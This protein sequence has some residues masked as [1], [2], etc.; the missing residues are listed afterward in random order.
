[1][2]RSIGRVDPRQ[3]SAGAAAPP[4]TSS[5]GRQAGSP[6]SPERDRASRSAPLT[7]DEPLVS[8]PRKPKTVD[9]PLA[10]EFHEALSLRFHDVGGRVPTR[11][12]T[13]PILQAL[14]ENVG[15]FLQ[16][17]SPT[18]MQRRKP[19]HG[20]LLPFLLEEF[21]ALVATAERKPIQ[22]EESSRDMLLRLRGFDSTG[23]KVQN[24]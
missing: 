6:S 5:E 1:M 9:E 13:D 3:A 23:R 19:Q 15:K 21:E 2:G 20:G 11:K 22:I 10:A 8:Q 14:G 4:K 18:E 12:Q 17:L 7:P 24:G 16:W